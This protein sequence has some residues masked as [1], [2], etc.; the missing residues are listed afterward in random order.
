MRRIGL[1]VHPT[2]EIERPLATLRE[3]A[4]ARGIEVVQLRTGEP[5][6]IVAD[7]GELEQ[8][9]LVVAIG[10]D[11]TV[12]AALRAA[13]ATSTPV[14]G[15]A[16][17]SLGALSAVTAPALADAL[18]R[19]E[20]GSWTR[21]DLPS[22]EVTSGGEAVAWALND[23]VPVRRSGQLV[24][25][26]TVDGELYARLAGDGVIV[27][28][29]LGSSA[30]SMAAGGPV[31]AE[32]TRAFVVTPLVAHGGSVPP[33][34]VRSGSEVTLDLH[35]GYDG[36]D[37]EIDGQPQ[38]LEGTRFGVRLAEA[39]ATL[40]VVSD[41]GLGLTALRRRGLITDSPRVLARDER[42]EPD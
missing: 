16:C 18:D 19:F 20:A 6:R 8:C 25:E 24:S 10:G 41:P 9:D 5:K 34:V 27:A 31:L 30:Y 11:G 36:F 12:L 4:S 35:P 7:F 3:W 28:T 29:P 26:V 13:A 40:V 22:L 37:V 33:L 1:V 32:G 17:G 14:L 15:V 2:R 42:E 21:R 38:T 39:K 23:F